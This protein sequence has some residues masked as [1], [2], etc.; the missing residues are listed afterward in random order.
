VVKVEQKTHVKIGDVAKII[1]G[2]VHA[3]P[4]LPADAG[5]TYR[6][7]ITVETDQG[8]TLILTLI[9]DELDHLEPWVEPKEYT[10]SDEDE[11]P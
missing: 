10:G 2:L 4:W 1:I 3:E 9:T 5:T 8:E 7:Q 6:R 11:K